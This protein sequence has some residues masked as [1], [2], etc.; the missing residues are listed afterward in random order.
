MPPT[1]TPVCFHCGSALPAGAT[2]MATLEGEPREFCCAGCETAARF[3]LAQGLGGYYA[4]RAPS[5]PAPGR[6]RDWSAFDRAEARRRY[7]HLRADGR[8]E[9]SLRVDGMHCAAC[10][11]LIERGLERL[12][13]AQAAH[14]DVTGARVELAY[15]ADRLPLSRVLATLEQLGF[16]P[17][18]LAFGNADTGEDAQ[19]RAALRRLGIAGIGMMQ[20]MTY[21][22]SLYAGAWHGMS[23]ALEALFRWVS[24]LVATPVVTYA[25]APFFL[26]AWRSLRAGT[27]G[28]DVPVALSIAAAYAA[29]LWATV[30]GTGTVYFDSVVM[31]TFFLTLGRFVEQSVRQR[32]GERQEAVA[33]LLPEAALRL[34]PDGGGERVLPEELAVGDLIRVRPGE[35]AP[36]D[37]EVVEGGSEFDE[38]LLTGESAPRV[39]GAGATVAAGTLN[40]RNALDLRVTRSGQDTTLAAAARLLARARAERP[41]VAATADAVATWFVGGVLLIAA[42]VG[43]YWSLVDTPRA[44]PA[45][46]AVL[47]VTCPCALSLATPAALAAAADRLAHA[48]VWV[49]RGRAVETLARTDAAVFDKTGTLTRGTPRLVRVELLA[50]DAPPADAPDAERQRQHWLAIAAGMERRSE[51]PMA[52]A[53]AEAAARD[54]VAHVRNVAGAGIAATVGGRSYRLGRAEFAAPGAFWR[55]RVSDD[56]SLVVLGDATGPLAAFVL[57]D[58]VRA[59]AAATL[60]A[61]ARRGLRVEIASGDRTEVVAAVAQRLGVDSAA[62]DLSPAEKLATVRRLQRQGRVVTVIGD[63]VNDAPVL[64]G[65]DVSVAVGGGTDLAKVSA[66]LVLLGDRLEPLADAVDVA[67]RTMRIVRENLAWAVLYNAVAVP[68]AA[69]GHLA[70]WLAALG[71]S[72]SSLLVV[73]NALRLR[74]RPAAAFASGCTTAPAVA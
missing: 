38:S 52:R 60:R 35:R 49:V 13:G 74:A 50:A 58:A 64:A 70:P 17:R 62:G 47:V 1:E 28:M 67:R 25:A 14:V 2:V 6:A 40:L 55:P 53:F 26:G 66:D 18:P 44:F 46:L 19:R 63:G 7:T 36:A 42:A 8:S 10:A 73:C 41:G 22:G 69:S 30:T 33:R 4:F 43:V 5:A 20:V 15:D 12:P 54:D 37:G 56:E 68:L 51:H 31:F 39:K 65:A 11:W 3:I 57:T 59:D 16:Q 72:A 34:L 27:L 23:P 48:G 29:S 61:L 24:L 9:V 32:A 45:V 71:M 21:A